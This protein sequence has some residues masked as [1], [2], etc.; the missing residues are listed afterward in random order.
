MRCP[1]RH[2]TPRQAG[3]VRLASPSLLAPAALLV[4]AAR[5]PR[6]ADPLCRAC[7][8]A[9][10]F[11][12][13]EPVGALRRGGLG[14]G[15]LRGPGRATSSGRSSSAAR[16]A[17]GRDGR[18]DRRQRARHAARRR[19]LGAGAAPPGRRRARGFNQAEAIAAAL[20]RAHRAAGGRLPRAAP[21]P[22]RITRS[23]AA[24]PR[25][26]PARRARS[27]APP[28]GR[29]PTALL[30]D[31][32][33]TT[34]ATLAACAAA[35]GAAGAREVAG[36]RLRAHDRALRPEARPRTIDCTSD[37]PRRADAHPGQGPRR[38]HR[39][40][41]SFAPEWRRS[42][43]RW[44]GRSR[45]WPSCE[46]ELRE[47]HNPA[48]R[49]SQVAEA[50]LHLKGVTLRPRERSTDMGRSINLV[51]TT[52]PA[53]SRSTAT[54]GAAAGRRTAVGRRT[55]RVDRCRAPPGRRC[56]RSPR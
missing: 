34:G 30:V 9:L 8:R 36:G 39:R 41:T 54:S 26:W 16:R 5:P 35:L 21:G 18:A 56:Y 14:A 49:E 43:G 55:G 17:R 50:T 46:I 28:A 47:E 40:T 33:V 32:V 29:P 10:R 22:T 52:W 27:H 19:T 38:R 3:P 25:G 20:G 31:D 45:R 1:R 2:R 7:R 24:A 4:A 13:P 51:P 11:L 44:R 48:I 23:A 6:R 12:A 53:R 37:S 15:R 42:S